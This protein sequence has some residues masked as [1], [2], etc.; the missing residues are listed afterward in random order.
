MK[1]RVFVVSG[2]ALAAM[3]ASQL[4]WKY[5][6][7]SSEEALFAP[8]VAFVDRHTISLLCAHVEAI[9]EGFSSGEFMRVGDTFYFCGG[10][11]VRITS[12]CTG[13]KQLFHFLVLMITSLSGGGFGRK[14]G[15]ILFGAI[16][17]Q[18]FNML[19]ISLLCFFVQ[20]FPTHWS[21]FHTTIFRFAFYVVLFLLW[22][23]WEEVC[24]S[25][26]NNSDDYS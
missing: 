25:L 8:V 23:F 7:A 20:V 9:L 4:V 5:G 1:G 13:T 18:N 3:C 19:R 16:L 15:F 14:V 11:F 17:L 6:V 2:V 10:G 12:G 21:F 22:I 24:S 26:K